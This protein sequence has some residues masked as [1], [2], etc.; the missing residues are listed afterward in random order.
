MFLPALEGQFRATL[1]GTSANELQFCVE[2]GDVCIETSKI[3]K[4]LFIN[5]GDNPFELMKDSIKILEGHKG[6]FAHIN[7]KKKPAHLDW[8]GWCTWDAFYKD[9]NRLGIK[10]G[11]ESFLEGG[12]PP[13]VLIIDNGWQDTLNEFEQEGEPLVSG[14]RFASRLVDFRESSKF[15]RLGVDISCNNLQDMVKFIKEKYSL[16]VVYVWH[17]IVGYCGGILP[18]SEKMKKYNLMMTYPIQSPGNVGNFRDIAMDS[19]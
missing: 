15:M 7:H 18:F 1:Q 19:L 14:T 9:V 6:T 13:K 5:S 11:L 3:S 16:K 12:C 17:A 8:F 4:A 2:S 10:E